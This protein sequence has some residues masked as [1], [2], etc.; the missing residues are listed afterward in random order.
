MGPLDAEGVEEADRIVGHVRQRVGH[1]GQVAAAEDRVEHDHRLDLLAVEVRRQSAVPVVEADHV[2]TTLG[3]RLAQL[4]VPGDELG[5]EAHHQEQRRI[6]RR[7]ER[8][9]LDLDGFRVGGGDGGAR[10]RAQS[11]GPDYVPT[12]W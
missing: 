11:A 9:V 8:L 10:H 12:R 3:Q 2:A 5:R 7:P 4:E 1:V 6:A